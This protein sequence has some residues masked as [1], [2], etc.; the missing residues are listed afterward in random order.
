MRKAVAAVLVAVLVF[1][2][3]L[4]ALMTFSVST[5][6][7]NRGFYLQLVSDERIYEA[8]LSETAWEQERIL[9]PRYL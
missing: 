9:L 5:W 1:P 8:I 7:F 6:V 3:L 4:A 2:L